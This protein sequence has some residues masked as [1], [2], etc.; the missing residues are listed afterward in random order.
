MA[1][2]T[3]REAMDT[4][5]AGHYDVIVAGGGASGLIAAVSGWIFLCDPSAPQD[6]VGDE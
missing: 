5:V 4:R 2:E 6:V 1:T 3:F